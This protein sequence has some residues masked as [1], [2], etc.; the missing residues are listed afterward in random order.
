MILPDYARNIVP[1]FLQNGAPRRQ[2]LDK[3]DA[4]TSLDE[5]KDEFQR[6]RDLDETEQDLA[7][8]IKGE[9]RIAGK[10]AGGET[11]AV[12]SGNTTKGDLTVFK[13]EPYAHYG[14]TSVSAIRLRPQ[15]ADRLSLLDNNNVRVTTSH[16]HV[17]HQISSD[18]PVVVKGPT[19]VTL[20][21]RASGGYILQS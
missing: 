11:T 8:G 19:E 13:N 12:F 14:S 15:T 4:Q 18:G 16:V 9:V 3:K 6:W 2:E 20:S 10:I 5:M 17:D 1:G 21:D 7:K